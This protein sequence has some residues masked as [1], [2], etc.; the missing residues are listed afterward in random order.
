MPDLIHYAA[1][2]SSADWH[3]WCVPKEQYDIQDHL[4]RKSRLIFVWLWGDAEPWQDL[5]EAL[6]AE[7]FYIRHHAAFKRRKYTERTF[8]KTS[9]ASSVCTAVV[10]MT[11]SPDSQ[12]AGVHT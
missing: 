4:L 9:S 11:S 3:G 12:F 6:D 1:V 2:F 10:I 8:S 7:W 5:M